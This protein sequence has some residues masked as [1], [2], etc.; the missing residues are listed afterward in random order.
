[1][2]RLSSLL[3]AA[4]VIAVLAAC[5]AAP[6]A[7]RL[8]SDQIARSAMA[9][10]LF[11]A[12]LQAALAAAIA[13]G[14]PVAAVEVCAISAPAIAA[15]VSAETGAEVRRV[16]L[17]P[18]NPGAAASDSLTT[19]LAALAK[20]PLDAAGQPA[21]VHWT[22]GEGRAARSNSM[23]AVIMRD[24]PCG[25]CHGTAITDNVRAAIAERYP[26]D[27]AVGFSAG[28]L[29]GAILISWPM[30]ERAQ[31]GGQK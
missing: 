1:M 27:Q 11:Q 17:R 25:A 14:G 10:D 24:Q 13:K 29:R 26:Q 9:A 6:A 19:H 16:S 28:D 7:A 5:V 18:R 4:S 20:E 31:P 22:E 12:R 2:P 21:W 30:N 8:N 15:E 3:G 23:R